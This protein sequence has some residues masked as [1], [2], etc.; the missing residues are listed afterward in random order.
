MAR[1]ERARLN[2]CRPPALTSDG[3]GVRLRRSRGALLGAPIIRRRVRRAV[4]PAKRPASY[5]R[6][7]GGFL[8]FWRAGAG[9]SP[10]RLAPDL[11]RGRS[12]AG[13]RSPLSRLAGLAPLLWL[14]AQRRGSTPAPARLHLRRSRR[15]DTGREPDPLLSGGRLQG[16]L[17][18]GRAVTRVDPGTA[19]SDYQARRRIASGRAPRPAR[20]RIIARRVLR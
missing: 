20:E 17:E 12:I 15:A 1:L 13:G 14:G 2:P 11:R 3:G 6:E 16:F 4:V 8:C 5:A 19:R 10:A 18:S 7:R 9:A